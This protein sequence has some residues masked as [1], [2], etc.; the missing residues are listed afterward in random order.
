MTLVDDQDNPSSCLMRIGEIS[1]EILI[2]LIVLH[3]EYLPLSRIAIDL[4]DRF[5]VDEEY[6]TRLE[7]SIRDI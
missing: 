4:V 7:L 6:L 3:G 2:S 5:P 1:G